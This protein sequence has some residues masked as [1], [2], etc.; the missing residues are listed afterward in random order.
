MLRRLLVPLSVLIALAGLAGAALAQSGLDLSWHVV[1]GGGDTNLVS[2]SISLGGTIGQPVAGLVQSG[3]A[4]LESGFWAALDVTPTATSTATATATGTPTAT[5]TPTATATGT[6]TATGTSTATPTGT[7]TPTATAT[8]TVMPTTTSSPTSTAVV[9]PTSTGTSTVPATPTVTPT[10]P[11][12]SSTPTA[13]PVPV[14]CAPRPNVGVAT[15]SNGDGRLRVTITAT[16]NAGTPTNA[17]SQIEVGA[18]TNARVYLELFAQAAP[19]TQTLAP[20]TTQVTLYVGRL[21][22]G[23]A[24]TVSL[25]VTDGCGAWPTFVG[26]GP[27]AF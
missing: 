27:D 22:A 4:S 17:L 21:T 5:D 13:T 7:L 2:G 9:S 3:D 10:P 25:V 14:R 11:R 19:F 15:A 12:P 23:Q 6:P 26:G 8:G 16:T 1:A 18:T 20:G 24:A